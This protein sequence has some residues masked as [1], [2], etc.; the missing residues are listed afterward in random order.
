MLTKMQAGGVMYF[1]VAILGWYM[2]FVMMAAEMRVP[3]KLPVGDLSR[4]W[5]RTDIDIACLEKKE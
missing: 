2:T 1:I 3:I 5:P 4:F